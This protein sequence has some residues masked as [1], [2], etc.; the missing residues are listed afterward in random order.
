MFKNTDCVVQWCDGE[1]T[2][3]QWVASPR[4]GAGLHNA[5]FPGEVGGK[6]FP[7]LNGEKV[8]LPDCMGFTCKANGMG[9]PQLALFKIQATGT[10][11]QLALT[12]SQ[13]LGWP[14]GRG[15]HGHFHS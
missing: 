2:R 5:F 14:S 8:L 1:A 4:K 10:H 12:G 11:Q 3:K 6:A 13:E 9:G 7:R 15:Q